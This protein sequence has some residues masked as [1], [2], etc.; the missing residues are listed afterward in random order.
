MHA[1]FIASALLLA[2]APA[3][4]QAPACGATAAVAL[5]CRQ[6]E[7]GA[8]ATLVRTEVPARGGCAQPLSETFETGD[9]DRPRS[10]ALAPGQTGDCRFADGRTV[11][12]RVQQEAEPI[13]GSC[14]ADAATFF[15]MWVD[16]R[17]VAS[18]R[19]VRARCETEP[20]PWSYRL[21]RDIVYDCSQSAACA[22]LLGADR[23]LS[24]LP[25]DETEYAVATPG[26]AA[27][28]LERLLDR[29][30]VCAEAERELTA[31]WSAFDPF[32][33]APF[34]GALRRLNAGERQNEVA[35]P[36]GLEFAYGAARADEFDFDNDGLIDQVYSSDSDGQGGW[37]Y[38]PLVVVS[39]ASA[40]GFAARGGDGAIAAVPCQWDRAHPPLSQC[41]DLRNAAWGQRQ[42]PTQSVPAPLPGIAGGD[43][44]FRT[45]Y[46][47]ALP[48]RFGD[49]TYVALASAGAP[50]RDYVAIF[51]P[52]PGGG[53][54]AVCLIRRVSP[55]M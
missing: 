52:R 55:N 29:G 25:V 15:S 12:V 14:N 42:P 23:A 19:P 47:T 46:T 22:P 18:Q 6:A 4:A 39:G 38:S 20:A 43:E 5:I 2:A 27:G 49:A 32:K 41:D 21:D 54:E 30:P 28:S 13:V 8:K 53:R 45:R 16:G 11:R 34:A 3:A 36:D 48:F 35:L 10:L 33:R 50:A 1:R 40:D 51:R 17:K 9:L 26:P 7:D 31:S 37:Y 24:S 44:F